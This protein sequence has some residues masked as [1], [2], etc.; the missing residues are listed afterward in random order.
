MKLK[1]LEK[2][3]I[4]FYD[5]TQNMLALRLFVYTSIQANWEV[6]DDAA[7]FSLS[8]QDI[9]DTFKIGKNLINLA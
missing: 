5:Y 2:N 1:N 7:T 3:P 4:Y 8:I 9:D 6:I